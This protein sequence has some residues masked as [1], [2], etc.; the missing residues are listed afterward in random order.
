MTEDRPFKGKVTVRFKRRDDGG[1]RAYCND[2]P[3]FYLSSIHRRDVM[4]DVIPALESL[5]KVNYDLNVQVSPLGYGIYS[6][7]EKDHPTLDDIPNV[8]EYEMEYVVDPIAA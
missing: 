8:P 2:V 7:I 4:H 6:L 1:L 3:G 5:M